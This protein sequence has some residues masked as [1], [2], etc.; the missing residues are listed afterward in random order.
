MTTA[1]VKQELAV[2]SFSK[3]YSLD[4]VESALNDLSE[5]A[6][7]ALRA[8]YEKM[9]KV[10]NLRF[11]VKPNRMPSVDDLAA[12]LPNFEEP[13]ADIRKQIALCLETDDRLE[14]MP[15][16]LLGEPGIGKTHF[17][18]Q[19]ARLLGTSNHYVAMSSLTAGWILSGASSQWR[20]AKPGKVFDALVNGSYAN[21]VM[22]VDEIDKA[23]G[24]AQYDPLGALYA[25]LEHDTAQTFVDEFAEVPINAGN[26]VWIATANDA[27]A[28]PEPLMNRMN[29]YE[30]P[31]PDRDGARR[32]AQSI[33]A[34]IRNAH[35]WGAR[36]PETLGDAP[37][38]ALT[39]ASPRGMRR[40]MLNA[41]GNARIDGR[42]HV[43]ARDVQIDRNLRKKAIGF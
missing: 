2:A 4:D 1:V 15:M 5:G 22:T 25:L 24:D 40:A 9:L 16:L 27:R 28:I 14:L 26:V 6:N 23:T 36:F 33:Y 8:T 29:V 35:S 3:V 10:G 32:I 43:E 11:C 39:Q 13:L 31:P 38:D 7:D 30:I 34:E 12:D 37:L 17:A 19:L 20:N 18:K 21:P 42:H 41:F